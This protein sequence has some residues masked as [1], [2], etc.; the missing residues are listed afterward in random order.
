MIRAIALCV[1]ALFAVAAAQA[2]PL[3]G[4]LKKIA[5]TKTI[6]IGFRTDAVPFS[7]TK[8]QIPPE[9]FSIDLCRRVVDSIAQQLKLPELKVSWIPVT[10]QSR[11]DAVAKGDADLECGSSSITLGRMKLVDFSNITFVEGTAAI[12][13]AAAG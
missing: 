7:F 2:Q 3:D 12:V 8:G 6:A 9:G 4:R 10:A 1:V 13:N 11:F 5:S